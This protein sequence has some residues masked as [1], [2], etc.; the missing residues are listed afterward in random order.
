MSIFKNPV[1][2]RRW[3]RFRESRRG[4]YSAWILLALTLCSFGAEIFANNRAL[5]VVHDG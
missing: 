5:I 3:Q 4:F 2:K 1:A